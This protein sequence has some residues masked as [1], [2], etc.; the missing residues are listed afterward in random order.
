MKGDFIL[1]FV[2]TI[3]EIGQSLSESWDRR[4]VYKGCRFGRERRR[5][6]QGFR[7]LQNRR[8]IIEKSG[9]RFKFTPK[10]KDWF[11]GVLL[12][13]F[14]STGQKWDNKWRVVIFDIPEELQRERVKFRRK[15]KSLGF[16]M[17]Q[18]SV[19]IFPYPCEEE[20]ARFAS[21]FKVGDYINI[22]ISE[23]AGYS[24]KVVKEFFGF[25]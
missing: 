6:D 24:D 17:L 19:F 9:G 7:N 3:T 1:K 11:Q 16:Y 2:E 20:V 13:Y 21:Y 8:I 12:K 5:I 25:K 22:L 23:S 4:P 10:G 15:L 18:K 14:K